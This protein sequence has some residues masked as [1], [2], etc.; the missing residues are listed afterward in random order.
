MTF[1]LSQSNYGKSDIRLV[2]VVRDEGRHELS[3]VTPSRIH[4]SVPRDN[5]PRAAGGT[6]Y[7]THRR[8]LDDADVMQVGGLPVTTVARTV[9][10][11]AAT[12][13][14]PHQLRQAIDRAERAGTLRRT[15]AADLRA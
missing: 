12:G 14:D 15:I 6:L 11:C 10:D 5:H 7:R 3:D 9:R 4:L 2:K 1:V 8:E 13:T